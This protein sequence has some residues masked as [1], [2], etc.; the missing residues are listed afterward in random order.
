MMNIHPA[1]GGARLCQRARGEGAEGGFDAGRISP[2]LQNYKVMDSSASN[3]LSGITALFFSGPP[4]PPQYLRIL[5][6]LQLPQIKQLN[7]NQFKNN[8][9][10]NRRVRSPGT[11]RGHQPGRGDRRVRPQPVCAP[12]PNPLFHPPSEQR[13]GAMP[14]PL[15]RGCKNTKPEWYAPNVCNC[16]GR[17]EATL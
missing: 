1:Q 6:Y 10:S 4:P 14:R 13:K 5:W 16:T 8:F 11:P 9:P 7:S 12:Q 2:D 3:F 17:F 15:V